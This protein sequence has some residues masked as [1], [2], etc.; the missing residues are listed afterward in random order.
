M[1]PVKVFMTHHRLFHRFAKELGTNHQNITFVTLNIMQ[2]MF[3]CITECL[4]DH[5]KKS[6][7]DKCANSGTGLEALK[8]KII[9]AQGTNQNMDT[10]CKYELTT[11]HRYFG[12]CCI[13]TIIVTHIQL[14]LILNT[15]YIIS[16]Q[17]PLF[18]LFKRTSLH[19]AVHVK[20][21]GRL[22][23]HIK[24]RQRDSGE[25]TVAGT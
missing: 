8:Q 17:S 1:D 20:A 18:I 9:A 13:V 14:F 3:C 7:V 11:N 2:K 5:L 25:G 10:E 12:H 23:G 22:Y 4:N 6:E 16:K 21:S 24:V 15:L 19:R